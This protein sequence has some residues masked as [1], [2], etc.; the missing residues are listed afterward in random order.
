MDISDI[1]REEPMNKKGLNRRQRKALA[2]LER[3]DRSNPVARELVTS[4]KFGCRRERDRTK[5]NRKVKHRVSPSVFY[6][7]QSTTKTKTPDGWYHTYMKKEDMD[8]SALPEKPGIYIFRGPRNTVLYIGRAT[9]L[10]S[11]VRSYFSSR[12]EADRGPRLTEALEK[13]RKIET[14]TTDSVLE[15][16]ILEANTIKKYEPPYNVVDKDNKSF[17]FVGITDETFPRVTTIRGRELEQGTAS[18]RY[19]HIF[20]PFPRGAMLKEALKVLR[21]ILPYRD[22]CSPAKDGKGKKCFRAQLGLC[23]GMCAGLIDAKTYKKRIREL[24]LFFSGRKK[25]LLASLEREMKQYAKQRE[26]ERAEEIRRRIFA[27]THIQDVALIKEEFS[28]RAEVMRIEAYD[29]AH[30]AGTN[31][32]GVMTVLIDGEPAPSE[33]RTFTIRDAAPGDDIGALREL[34]ERRLKHAEWRFPGLIVID[35]GKTQL[36]AARR[37]LEEYGMAIPTVSVVK[38]EKHTPREVLGDAAIVQKHEPRIIQANA[39]AHRFAV[40]RHRRKRTRSMLR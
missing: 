36:T 4:G 25:Q 24:V 26:F 15:A 5:Y 34:L 7:H 1:E 11:R 29:V 31:T 37:V 33:Y 9:D 40:S 35:G 38:T 13:T 8:F 17:Q 19:K 21:R 23:P 20:G 27:L 16:Y 14:K 32:V 10:R 18:V 22:T 6:L 28:E 12:L 30:L 3:Q 39:E 2:K